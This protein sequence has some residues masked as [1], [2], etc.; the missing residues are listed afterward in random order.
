M[1]GATS[2]C[3]KPMGL[4]LVLMAGLYHQSSEKTV[5]DRLGG[6]A[7]ITSSHTLPSRHGRQLCPQALHPM[8]A[9]RGMRLQPVGR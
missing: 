8:P 3:L 4:V 5:F 6:M 9:A 2:L 7:L 1:S